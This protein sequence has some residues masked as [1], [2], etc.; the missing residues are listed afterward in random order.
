MDIVNNN[1]SYLIKL[2]S[3]SDIEIFDKNLNLKSKNLILKKCEAIKKKELK[4]IK[5]TSN[6]LSNLAKLSNSENIEQ[7]KITY[8]N[9]EHKIN[10]INNIEELIKYLNTYDINKPPIKSVRYIKPHTESYIES[11]AN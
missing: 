10:N 9:L 11:Y 8:N 2:S 1:L 7:I 4:E 5:K 3:E 6:I